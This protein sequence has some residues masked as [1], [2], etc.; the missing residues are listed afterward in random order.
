MIEL[1]GVPVDGSPLGELVLPFALALT[2]RLHGR[3][4]LIYSPDFWVGSSDRLA[5]PAEDYK[6][7]GK[8]LEQV[9]QALADPAT[10]NFL[11]PDRIMTQEIGLSS[12]GTTTNLTP[13]LGANII[14]MPTPNRYNLFHLLQVNQVPKALEHGNIPLIVLKTGEGELEA[15]KK[16]TLQKRLQLAAS[17]PVSSAEPFKLLVTLDGTSEAESILFPAAALATQVGGTIYL[18]RVYFEVWDSEYDGTELS[19][20]E[21]YGPEIWRE[22]A[23]RRDAAY[24]YL[25]EIKARLEEQG[26]KVVI[27]IRGGET[28][29]KILEYSQEIGASMLATTGHSRNK[30]DH[31]VMGSLVYRVL[32]YSQKP[33][34]LVISTPITKE[35]LAAEFNQDCP[36]GLLQKSLINQ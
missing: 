8:Y 14:V 26:C 33:V 3:L 31:L 21:F 27:A 36:P 11:S 28:S 2:N 13:G 32:N 4:L 35:I 25:K 34:L 29:E 15:A 12:E 1:V 9:L 16:L 22:N 23:Y 30:K 24:H 7:V 17:W 20:D 19:D 6:K 5:L 18:L 10:P